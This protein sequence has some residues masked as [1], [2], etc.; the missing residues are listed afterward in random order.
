MAPEGLVK[1]SW[2]KTV[3]QLVEESN[4]FCG[5]NN[6]YKPIAAVSVINGVACH[7]LHWLG[8]P[9]QASRVCS[10]PCAENG[11]AIGC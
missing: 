1:P 7:G 8:T 11:K 9:M 3:E 5:S 2:K 10:M 4:D 6:N